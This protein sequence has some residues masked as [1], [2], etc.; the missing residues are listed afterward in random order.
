MGRESLHSTRSQAR[1]RQSERAAQQAGA[2]HAAVVLDVAALEATAADDLASGH[3]APIPWKTGEVGVVAALDQTT[4]VLLI[5]PAP[6][7]A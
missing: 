2:P 5:A 3:P 6:P 4:T 1:G 7:S